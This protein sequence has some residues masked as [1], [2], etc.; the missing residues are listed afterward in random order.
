[1]VLYMHQI[2]ACSQ[3]SNSDTC[4]DVSLS[5]ATGCA[6]GFARVLK[7]A[8]ARVFFNATRPPAGQV[9]VCDR[10]WQH[11]ITHRARR[12]LGAQ[13][14]LLVLFALVSKT[15]AGH[16]LTGLAVTLILSRR[17]Y[18]HLA[19]LGVMPSRLST[20]TPCRGQIPSSLP[21][22]DSNHLQQLSQTQACIYER[23]ARDTMCL[24]KTVLPRAPALSLRS[25]P[26]TCRSSVP[27]RRERHGHA[28]G[29]RANRRQDPA[30][31]CVGGRRD[32]RQLE[33]QRGGYRRR[34]PLCESVHA[35]RPHQAPFKARLQPRYEAR[36]GA[37]VP[38]G[39]R[40]SHA[41][42]CMRHHACS[43]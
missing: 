17:L 38:C 5:C 22:G 37:A 32:G 34:D 36:R 33:A 35:L 42:P 3:I 27:R 21:Q 39:P 41:A 7:Q 25:A 15:W 19:S 18:K 11:D 20:T 10:K 24:Y 16:A 13:Q 43:A 1:M 30:R 9:S 6:L 28:G 12:A 14:P 40:A 26:C 8:C 29:P 23:A 31:A 4:L 2:A